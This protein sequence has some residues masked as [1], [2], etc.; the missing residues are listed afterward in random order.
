TSKLAVSSGADLALSF[1]AEHLANPQVSEAALSPAVKRLWQRLSLHGLRPHEQTLVKFLLLLPLA[2][3]I[4]SVCRII[5]GVPT[6]GT[7][8]PALIGLAFLDVK[9]L[10]WGLPVFVVLVLTGWGMRHFLE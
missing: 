8:S 6:F 7:F 9:A 5:I 2:A 1:R 4:V 3:L 10:R